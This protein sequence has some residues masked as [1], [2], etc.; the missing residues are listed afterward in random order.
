MCLFLKILVCT[1]FCEHVSSIFC[2]R[3]HSS[4]FRQI[5]SYL[6]KHVCRCFFTHPVRFL[7]CKSHVQY[8]PFELCTVLK[9]QW[10]RQLIKIAF[11]K[12]ELGWLRRCK[13]ISVAK[14]YFST[15]KREVS[16]SSVDESNESFKV[17]QWC[18]W[19]ISWLFPSTVLGFL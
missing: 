13:N 15:R 12:Y 17:K 4:F 1:S 18:L 9:R 10:N 16:V 6:R 19:A 5:R 7:C 8:S 2:T 11:L 14:K 3:A